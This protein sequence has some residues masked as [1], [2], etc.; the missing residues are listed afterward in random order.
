[1][2]GPFDVTDPASLRDATF[3]KV[4][5]GYDRAEV[6]ALLHAVALHVESLQRNRLELERRLAELHAAL[7]SMPT[8]PEPSGLDT[9]DE[10]ALEALVGV[11]TARVLEAAREAAAHRRAAADE[12]YD[13]RIAAAEV[14]VERIRSGVADIVG[15]RRAEAEAIAAALLA[16]AE[17]RAAATIAAAEERAARLRAE[18]ETGA[19]QVLVDA[20]SEANRRRKAVT[21][22]LSQLGGGVESELVR[23]RA[24]A[25]ELV[26]E[27]ERAREAILTDLL[28]RRHQLRYQ[29]EQLRTGRDRMLRAFLVVRQGVENAIRQA[30]ASLPDARAAAESVLPPIRDLTVDDLEAE[31]AAA[32]MLGLGT[33]GHGQEAAPV[34]E[35]ATVAA[36]EDDRGGDRG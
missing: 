12:E 33:Y 4:F 17:A 23:A 14:E 26:A 3:G 30:E 16:D 9:L 2:A 20:E 15:E 22:E 36:D 1:M 19:A 31:I 10:A 29:I 32:R 8:T 28:E 6:G 11:E 35:G 21:E 25:S 5:R 27:A 18:A 34:V 24:E 7:E 13:R